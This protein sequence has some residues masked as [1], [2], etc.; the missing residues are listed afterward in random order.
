MPPTER[1]PLSSTRPRDLAPSMNAACRASSGKRKVAF[2][3]GTQS[4][5]AAALRNLYEQGVRR[6]LVIP[7]YPQYSATTTASVFDSVTAILR[8][9]RWLPELRF[10]TQYHD[11]AGYIDAI[12][13]NILDHWRT[14]PRNHLL[15]SFHGVPRSY[16]LAGDPYHCQSLKTARLVSERLGLSSDEWSVSF[17]SQVGRAEWLRPYTDELLIQYAKSGHKR[18]SVICPGFK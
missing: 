15:F 16:L 3:T 4:G 8:E 1:C 18:I 9:Y 10:V 2:I 11:D 14:N 13:A 7:L 6:L 17:Q 12:A 5:Y